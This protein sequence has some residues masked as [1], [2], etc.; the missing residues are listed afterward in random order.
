MGL[1]H[2]GCSPAGD[3]KKMAELQL[4]KKDRYL[5]K[6]SDGRILPWT[7]RLSKRNDMR[8]FDPEFDAD[9]ALIKRKETA[10]RMADLEQE[11]SRLR[12]MIEGRQAE[13]QLE[14]M[15]IKKAHKEDIPENKEKDDKPA[16]LPDLEEPLE[17]RSPGKVTREFLLPKEPAELR[18]FAFKVFG[19][20]LHPLCKQ[21]RLIDDILNLQK[22]EDLQ[23]QDI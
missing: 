12:K 7:L 11:N 21:E 5:E 15:P 14:T 23:G 13:A 16:I 6:T 1:T 2:N 4:N 17:P 20:K 9:G 10:E 8:E 22:K 19:K 18:D 3:V